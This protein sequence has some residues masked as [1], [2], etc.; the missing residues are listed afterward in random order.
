[1]ATIE[2]F[3]KKNCLNNARQAC[4]DPESSLRDPETCQQ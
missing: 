1:M 3:E 2:F 4:V